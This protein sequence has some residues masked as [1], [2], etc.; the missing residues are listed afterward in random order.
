MGWQNKRLCRIVHITDRKHP[1]KYISVWFVK[2]LPKW[3]PLIFFYYTIYPKWRNIL[4][5]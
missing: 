2:T 4:S 3:L 5:I 1:V